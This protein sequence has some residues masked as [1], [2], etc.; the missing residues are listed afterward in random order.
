M[1]A[2]N[3]DPAVTVQVLLSATSSALYPQLE[4]LCAASGGRISARVI[5]QANAPAAVIARN[6]AVMATLYSGATF[7]EVQQLIEIA[8]GARA[9]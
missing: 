2:R 9:A 7:A 8:L 5:E 4:R 6:G 3:D 1:I